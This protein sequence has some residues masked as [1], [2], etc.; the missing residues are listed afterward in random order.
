[1]TRCS[2]AAS[3]RTGSALAI[4]PTSPAWMRSAA[5]DVIAMPAALSRRAVGGRTTVWPDDAQGEPREVDVG[6]R[7]IASVGHLTTGSPRGCRKLHARTPMWEMGARYRQFVRTPSHS[8]WEIGATRAN[9]AHY[10]WIFR[11]P[12]T[13]AITRMMS[14]GSRSRLAVSTPGHRFGQPGASNRRVRPTIGGHF[15][16]GGIN[17]SGS[18]AMRSSARSVLPVRRSRSP[19]GRGGSASA[20]KSPWWM[21]VSMAK[22]VWSRP[23]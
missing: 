7:A 15:L 3:K 12:P 18:S 17:V 23:G 2:P 20:D 9:A 5:R 4:A 1:M 19:G 11:Q 13:L 16:L 10:L 14:T 22:K 21:S 8:T 6:R